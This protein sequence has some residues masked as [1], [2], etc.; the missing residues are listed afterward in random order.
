MPPTINAGVPCAAECRAARRNPGGLR[1]ASGRHRAAWIAEGARAGINPEIA[2]AFFVH[3]SS[4]GTA[5]GW[6]GEA[7]RHEHT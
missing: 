6:A 4:A 3:E 2:L 1:L 7:R 5:P